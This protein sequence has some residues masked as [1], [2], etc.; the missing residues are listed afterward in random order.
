MNNIKAARKKLKAI[1]KEKGYWGLFDYLE[2]KDRIFEFYQMDYVGK[3]LQPKYA[4]LECTLI[5]YGFIG[6][7]LFGADSDDDTF[8]KVILPEK[9]SLINKKE[10]GK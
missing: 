2:K 8:R 3:D 5:D 7:F 1:A 6:S 4:G 9:L 10:G